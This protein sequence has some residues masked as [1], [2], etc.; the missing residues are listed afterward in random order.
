MWALAS[1]PLGFSL[2]LLPSTLLSPSPRL[3]LRIVLFYSVS[4]RQ[5]LRLHLRHPPPTHQPP[6]VPASSSAAP[7]FPNLHSIILLLPIKRIT[8][9]S[10][11]TSGSFNFFPPDSSHHLSS[12]KPFP[13]SPTRMASVSSSLRYLYSSRL[14]LAHP[15]DSISQ[16]EKREKKRSGEI[17]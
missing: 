14:N 11:F 1:C 9:L 10:L 4:W 17:I 8:V 7:P 3:P 16:D 2:R 6:R 15:R 13:L 5:T 12:Q